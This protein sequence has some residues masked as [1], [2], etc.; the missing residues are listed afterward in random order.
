MDNQAGYHGANAMLAAIFHRIRTGRGS[1]IDLSAVEAFE[2]SRFDEAFQA[3]RWGLDAE[4]ERRREALTAD[5]VMLGRWF[6]AL[7]GD[8]SAAT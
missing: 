2:I 1:L 3:R 8:G 4:A 6:A 5:A 7:R